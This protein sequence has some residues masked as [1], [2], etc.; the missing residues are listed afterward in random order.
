MVFGSG[1]VREDGV[2]L[3]VTDDQAHSDSR[4]G[5]LHRD[6]GV[7]EGERSAA[8][9]GHGRGTIGFQNV[10]DEAHSVGK[11]RFGRKQV[12]Q[13]ALRES[14][15]ADFAAARA[16][17]EFHFTDAERREVVVQHEAIEL[18]LLEEQVEALHV[19]LGAQGQS[20]EGL[21]FAAGK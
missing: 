16:S 13:R 5:S 18:V 20:G 9:G 19:F 7:H 14:A 3:V 4:A 1:D 6:A 15:M 12:H 8:D 17:K 2:F 21:G 10:G 11:I